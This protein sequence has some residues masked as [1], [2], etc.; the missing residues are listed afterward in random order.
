MPK[1]ES[2][3]ID[4]CVLLSDPEVIVRAAKIGFPIITKVIYQE[5]DYNNKK[6]TDEFVKKNT[7]QIIRSLKNKTPV[8]MTELPCGKPLLDG[9]S[10]RKFDYNGTPLFVLNRNKYSNDSSDNDA[11]IREVA[12]DYDLILVT[13][14]GANKTLAD[15]DGIRSAIWKHPGSARNHKAPPKANSPTATPFKIASVVHSPA[16]SK[17]LPR[18]M[19]KQ[20]DRVRIGKNGPEVRI[21]TLV[22]A[23]G[24]GQVFEI[25]GENR[26]VKIY[27]EKQLTS[28]RIAKLELMSSRSVNFRGICWPEELI[29]TLDNC[30]VGYVMQRARG[31][32]LQKSVFV[33]P[34]LSQ[35][36]PN[37]HRDNLVNICISFLESMQFLHSLNV[38]VGDINPLNI[39]VD[40]D[41]SD[42]FIVDV[43]SFQVE[44]FPCPVGTVNFSPADLQGNN[45]RTILRTQEDELFA[46][47]TMLFMVLMPGKPPY[48]QQGGESPEKNIRES[49]FPY[50]LGEDHKGRNVSPGLWRYIWSHL[51]YK[52]KEAFHRAFR[53]NERIAIS[54][55]LEILQEYKRLIGK[56]YISNEIFPTGFK[57]PKGEGIQAVC[58][59][60]RCGKTFEMHR[61]KAEEIKKK[62]QSPICPECLRLQELERLA[63]STNRNGVAREE[64]TKTQRKAPSVFSTLSKRSTAKPKPKLHRPPRAS[65]SS[66]KKQNAD[67]KG[68]F[69]SIAIFV[70][71]LLFLA[72]KLGWW[73]VPAI[74]LIVI[75][76][77]VLGGKIPH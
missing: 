58:S 30:P 73:A 60:Q 76:I 55:W 24:E 46:V 44:G 35:K 52:L 33:K 12:K 72:F 75:I 23:G 31:V 61:D 11:K 9:D 37:W 41:G 5:I 51:P 57:I 71:V 36:F 28:E 45:F 26:V 63:T 15:I 38:L 27:H 62:G 19:P 77:G 2:A 67:E 21:S 34:L 64:P 13:E 6:S 4:T 10:L 65:S 69:I 16:S 29:Y 14:D 47:S 48:S 20:D 54:E 8:E 42:I 18:S 50:P 66:T 49:N 22:G 25:S 74:I 56:E 39:L 53:K 43:D 40:G 1:K 7:R 3:I 17:S 68:G 59:R 32:P 70:A